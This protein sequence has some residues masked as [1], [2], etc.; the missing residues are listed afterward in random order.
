MTIAVEHYGRIL[1]TLQKNQP[2]RIDLE[3]KN[4]FYDDPTSFNVVGEI[5]GTD[6]ADEVVMLGAHFDSWHAGTGA[7]DNAAGSAVMMEA[8]RILKQSGL[9]AAAHG[10]HRPVG[11]RRAGPASAR[12]PT[13]PSTSP[14]ARR[15]PLKPAHAKLSG[16]FNVDN[17]TGAIRG[18]Y[19]QG[20]EARRADLRGVDEALQQP[21]HDAR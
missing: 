19:L 1:R 2:V 6:K 5:P 15:W 4:T 11:R 12:A 3:V 14:T 8:M 16:Y 13:S 7:T 20:N 17:G 18:V 10:A 21:R 9:H